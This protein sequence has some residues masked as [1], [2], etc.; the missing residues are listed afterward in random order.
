MLVQLLVPKIGYLSSSMLSSLRVWIKR[1]TRRWSSSPEEPPSYIKILL[2]ENIRIHVDAANKPQRTL[3]V[4]QLNGIRPSLI[5]LFINVLYLLCRVK[6]SFFFLLKN[7]I[8]LQILC[9]VHGGPTLHRCSGNKDQHWICLFL[10]GN[11]R[12]KG[13]VLGLQMTANVNFPGRGSLQKITH[14][15]ECLIS[16]TRWS[17]YPHITNSCLGWLCSFY[18]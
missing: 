14:I 17:C 16:V 9:N 10:L 13:I 5:S 18:S 7:N 1:E 4:T 6:M 11:L 15:H 3:K 2:Y 8:C 12:V